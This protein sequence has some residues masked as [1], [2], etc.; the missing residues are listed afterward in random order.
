MNTSDKKT[1]K[2]L[3]GILFKMETI[4]IAA[5]CLVIS[6]LGYFTIRTMLYRDYDFYLKDMLHYVDSMID[7]DDMTECMKT[8]VES[9]KY[10]ELQVF[11][12]NFKDRHSIAWL[13]V[14]KPIN[15]SDNDNIMNVI[16]A[17]TPW[18]KE[19]APENEVFLNE[20][21]GTSYTADVAKLYLDALDKDD[22]TYFED[23]TEEWGL[24]YTAILPLKNSKGEAIA[25]LCVDIY[26]NDIKENLMMYVIGVVILMLLAGILYIAL[27]MHWMNRRIIRPIANIGE[28]IDS[29]VNSRSESNDADSMEIKDP[30]IKTGDELQMLSE[31]TVDMMHRLKDHVLEIKNI[32]AEKERVT[33]ELNVAAKMQANMLPK[34]FLKHGGIDIYATMTPAKEMGGDFYDFF[35]IDDDHIGLIMADVSGKGV[36]AAMFMIV[37]K[38]LMKVRTTAPGS[39]AQMLYDINNMLCADNPSQLFVTAWFGILT[40]SSGEIIAAN[41]GHEQPALIHENGECELVK[42]ENMPPLATMEDIEYIDEKIQLRKGDR[43]FL[44]TDGVPEAKAPDGSRFGNDRMLAVLSSNKNESSEILLKNMKREI[45]SFTGTND[46]FDDVTMMSVTWKNKN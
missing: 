28:C 29:F 35:M 15:D 14:I 3:R 24:A 5:L 26:I 9:E 16:A 37:A 30:E 23:Y 34:E 12:D 46:P 7:K 32:T 1:K 44:Y 40:I 19:N 21:C 36:P 10:Q 25:E 6:V 17:M 43:I 2:K 11:L 39:P 27:N 31:Q 8:G 38:T 18:E 13:Y 33:A 41:A 42:V 20:L 22:I 45:D 4:F